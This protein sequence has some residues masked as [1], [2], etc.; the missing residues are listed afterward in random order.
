MIK[1]LLIFLIS[2]FLFLF[3]A[4]PTKASTLYLSPATTNIPQGS[5][6]SVS[7]GI[8]TAGES[9][10][11]VSAYLSYPADKL[12][13]AWISY[14]SRFDLAA[15][16][17]YGGG[18]IR[19]SRGS[20]N[21]VVGNVTVA[22]I[23]FKG[24]A[25]GAATV[26]FIGGSGAPRTSDSSDSLILGGSTGGTFTIGEPLK[27]TPTAT[28]AVKPVISNIV[29]GTSTNS[30]TI[31]W[32][33]DKESDST[34]E[35][36]LAPNKYFLSIYDKTL[37][38]THTAKLEGDALTAGATFHF[39]VKSKDEAGNERVSKD[40]TL[41]LIGHNISI[42]ALDTKGNPL[43]DSEVLLYTTAQRARTNSN[44]EASFSNV[45][46][47][48]HLVVVKTGLIE[49]TGEIDVTGTFTLQS[50]TLTLDLDSSKTL[51]S[52]PFLLTVAL[53]MAGIVIILLVLIFLKRRKNNTIQVPPQTPIQNN[54]NTV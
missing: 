29:A 34:V 53:S 21:G 19:I 51:A 47:G 50:F 8:N 28:D 23:G 13:V 27:V 12:E 39:M 10:N 44:G 40:S 2:F 1:K 11:G 36:G 15:E 25:Q 35:Y 43:K 45:T 33:T 4:Q 54:E 38:A 24:K 3:I 32:D 5:T 41:Q 30:A 31:S 52:S 22:T 17:T 42:K 37:T 9:V 26:S 49:K 6:V 16:G 14:G 20:I 7:V 46:E 18:S 48:Q